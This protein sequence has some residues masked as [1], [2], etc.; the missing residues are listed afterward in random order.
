MHTYNDTLMLR[1]AKWPITLACHHRIFLSFLYILSTHK[2]FNH[3]QFFL[4]HVQIHYNTYLFL[5]HTPI[6]HVLYQHLKQ[7]HLSIET[8][9]WFVLTKKSN[10]HSV[11]AWTSHMDSYQHQN[12]ITFSILTYTSRTCRYQHTNQISYPIHTCT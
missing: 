9:K 4:S 8:I 6:K 10:H 2:F 7:I 1:A 12:Q 3:I 5:R 11:H